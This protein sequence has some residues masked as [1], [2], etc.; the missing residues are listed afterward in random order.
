[1][2]PAAELVSVATALDATIEIAGPDG[3]RTIPMAEFPLGFMTPA[4]APEEM[5]VAVHIPLPATHHGSCFTEFSRRHGDFRHGLRRRA[6][7][8]RCSRAD[9][10]RIHH[11]G[12][13]RRCPPAPY[14]RPRTPGRGGPSR[15]RPYS[16]PPPRMAA[17]IE[18]MDDAQVPRLVPATPGHGARPAPHWQPHH[19]RLAA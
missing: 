4:V 10:P 9:R 2:D 19:T 7:D 14:P 8:T 16:P 5:L 15:A 1:M 13:R 17:T 3:T 18:A 12:R 6:A 11:P